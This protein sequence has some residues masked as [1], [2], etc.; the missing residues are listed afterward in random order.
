MRVINHFYVPQSSQLSLSYTIQI[1]I[2]G[3]YYKSGIIIPLYIYIYIMTFIF[4][5][6]FHIKTN[7]CFD[8]Q[9][10]SPNLNKLEYGDMV[11]S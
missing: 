4:L 3:I 8:G 7:I 1:I 6:L 9:F 11:I 10:G 5:N 2:F